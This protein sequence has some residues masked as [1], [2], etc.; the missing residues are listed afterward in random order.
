[1]TPSSTEARDLS[2]ACDI[3]GLTVGIHIHGC[4]WEDDEGV[5][6]VI[7]EVPPRSEWLFPSVVTDEDEA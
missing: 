4:T 6:H 5:R 1:V 7:R 2:D 3:C